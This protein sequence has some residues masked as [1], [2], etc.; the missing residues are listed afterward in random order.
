MGLSMSHTQ[1][2]NDNRI[3]E[4]SAKERFS[5]PSNH[6]GIEQRHD[7]L[8]NDKSVKADSITFEPSDKPFPGYGGND[9]PATPDHLYRS[10]NGCTVQ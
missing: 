10:D 1:P 6:V 3:L 9:A 4:E 8:F 2:F 7:I 5:R